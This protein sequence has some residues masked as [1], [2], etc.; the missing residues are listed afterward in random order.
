[1][2][3]INKHFKEQEIKMPKNFD[4]YIDRRNSDSIKWNLYD[5]DVLPMW[6]ADMD[7][8]APPAVLQ[9]LHNRVDHGVFGYAGD[10]IALAKSDCQPLG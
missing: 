10:P 3:I 4:Q 5:S 1:M 8:S 6:V 7:Y 9:A 2:I